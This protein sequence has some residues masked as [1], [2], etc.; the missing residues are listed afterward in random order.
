MILSN[1]GE[2]HLLPYD[3]FASYSRPEQTIPD[4]I[5]HHEEWLEAIRTGSPTTC[6]FE[7]SGALSE[8]VL[9]G[10]V[11][12]KAGEE[13]H[14]DAVKFQVTNSSKANDLLHK[15]YRKGWTL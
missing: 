12:F 2:H 8:A 5:G 4:S 14:W 9:L 11:A 13:I 7:Y 10:V 3:K 15:E 6:N 1:Y